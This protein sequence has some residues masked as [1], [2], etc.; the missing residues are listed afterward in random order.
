MLGDI[1]YLVAP[2]KY[3]LVL[4]KPNKEPIISISNSY[5]IIYNPAMN[6]VNEISFKIDKH[7]SNG[8]INTSYNKLEEKYLIRLN[9]QEFF[10]I[11]EID[12]DEVNGMKEIVAYS[13]EFELS[14]KYIQEYEVTSARLY[15]DNSDIPGVM[16]LI[17]S[18]SPSWAV[19][20]IDAEILTKYRSF[21]VSNIDI[22]SFIV[23]NIQDAF[24]CIAIFN[25]D[26]K[27]IDFKLLENIGTNASLFLSTDNLVNELSRNRS[28]ENIATRVYGYGDE[29]LRMNAVNPYGGK[30]YIDNWSYYRNLN[31]MSQ[32]LMDA[33]D[34]QDAIV[35]AN[36]G[37]FQT[38]SAEYDVAY[39]DEYGSSTYRTLSALLIS[40]TNITFPI[41]RLI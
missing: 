7:Y 38:V 36:I 37:E 23:K 40:G 24:E 25:T 5:E 31:W 28:L 20:D 16:N 15:S 14:Q 3:T 32:G 11:S 29:D 1:N 10:V 13:L 9:N 8:E 34:S 18:L 22:Y 39:E 35:A 17:N 6:A 4:T 2:I 19:G 33:L 41:M 12:E 27:T 21:D 26:D 30:S